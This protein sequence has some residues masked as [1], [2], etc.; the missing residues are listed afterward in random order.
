MKGAHRR[1]GEDARFA[2]L[3][4]ALLMQPK[5]IVECTVDRRDVGRLDGDGTNDLGSRM[6]LAHIAQCLARNDRREIVRVGRQ[7]QHR[8]AR[9]GLAGFCDAGRRG[10]ADKGSIGRQIWQVT[11]L[12]T[13][14]VENGGEQRIGG[15]GIGRI[16]ERVDVIG[17]A[18]ADRQQL[19]ATGLVQFVKRQD[20]D[21]CLIGARGDDARHAGPKLAPPRHEPVR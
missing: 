2:A 6:G 20:R 16:D 18:D 10:G 8:A 7:C 14:D 11:F 4:P 19:D 17:H 13:R 21:Q 5:Q 12:P 1:I 15:F 3:M 9:P